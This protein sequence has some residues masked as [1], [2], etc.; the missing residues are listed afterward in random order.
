MIVVIS[1][2]IVSGGERSH[3]LRGCGC[4]TVIEGTRQITV[5]GNGV[6]WKVVQCV[7]RKCTSTAN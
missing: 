2:I 3:R 7:G 1:F 4:C 6:R 5:R